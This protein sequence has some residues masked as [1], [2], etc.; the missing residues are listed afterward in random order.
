MYSNGYVGNYLNGFGNFMP[1][2]GSNNYNMQP[3][4]NN[5]G[6]TQQNQVQNTQQ[7]QPSQ[8]MKMMAIPVGSLEEAKAFQTAYDGTVLYLINTTK[9]EVYAKYLGDKGNVEFKTFVESEIVPEE[10]EMS[11][12]KK[13]IDSL[14]KQL[15]ATSKKGKSKDDE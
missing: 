9:G 14:E 11:Q 12:L 13:R 15:S 3:N 8:Q 2:Y 10:S 7:V 4:M 1:S 5:Y 6:N